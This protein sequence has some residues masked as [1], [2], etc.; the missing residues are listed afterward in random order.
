MSI[1]Y[2]EIIIVDIKVRIVLLEYLKI[3]LGSPINSELFTCQLNPEFLVY[4]CQ[5]KSLYRL[6]L[7]LQ[8]IL[9]WMINFLVQMTKVAKASLAL[10]II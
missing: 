7:V 8:H 9:A 1:R 4:H 5:N 6:F 2:N 3:V 10:T